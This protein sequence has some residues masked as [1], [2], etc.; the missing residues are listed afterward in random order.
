MYPWPSLRGEG[1]MS[2]KD[3][4]A[5]CGTRVSTP[6]HHLWGEIA[7]KLKRNDPPSYHRLVAPL[8]TP[9]MSRTEMQCIFDC[10]PQPPKCIPPGRMQPTSSC[11]L[12]FD[13]LWFVWPMS[14][15]V[16]LLL[17]PTT[18]THTGYLSYHISSIHQIVSPL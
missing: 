2:T 17:L 8:L 9:L 7:T 11:G 12:L 13:Q 6:S 5:F 1:V 18:N 15:R 14:L 4:S 10:A 16:I 3:M